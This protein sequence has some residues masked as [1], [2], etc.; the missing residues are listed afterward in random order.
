MDEGQ[1][2]ADA[3]VDD[4]HLFFGVRLVA[5]GVAETPHA[6]YGAVYEDAVAYVA[7]R[8]KIF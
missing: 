7:L 5:E 8:E 4:W 6:D 1:P 2:E 3:R